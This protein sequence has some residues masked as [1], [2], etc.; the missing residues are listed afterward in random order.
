[1]FKRWFLALNFGALVITVPSPAM[2]RGALIHLLQMARSQPNSAAFREAVV[3][4]LSDDRIKKGTAFDSNGP[5]FIF[6]VDT[7]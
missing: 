7:T 1:M 4:G 2:E 5:D 3:S 6:A